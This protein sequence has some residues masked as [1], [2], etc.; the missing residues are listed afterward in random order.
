MSLRARLQR[1]GRRLDG[2]PD[3]AAAP[4]PV[5]LGPAPTATRGGRLRPGQL[6]SALASSAGGLPPM[7]PDQALSPSDAGVAPGTATGTFRGRLVIV[8]GTGAGSGM[9]VYNGT[10]GPGN[11]PVFAVVAP[12]VTTDPYGNTVGAVMTIGTFGGPGLNVDQFGNLALAGADGSLLELSPEA[13]LPFSLTAA[14]AGV[15]QTL[16][17]MQTLDLNE[18]QAGVISGLVLGSGASAKMGTL[19]TAPYAAQGMGLLLQAQND[20]A[21]D[22]PWCTWGT[23]TTQGGALTF[24]PLMA[25]GPQVLLLYSAG[26]TITVATR[27][28]GSGNITITGGATTAKA[29]CWAGGTAGPGGS[30]GQGGGG[31]GAAEYAAEPALAVGATVAYVVGGPGANSTV[32]GSAVTVTAHPGTAGSSGGA[33][34]AGGTGSANTTH[35]N[36]GQGGLGSNNGG[37]G[38]GGGSAGPGGAGHAGASATTSSG[39]AGGT[40]VSGGAAGGRGGDTAKNGTGGSAPG[41][42]GGGGGGGGGSLG[43]GSGGGGD[44]GQI[45]V[46]WSSG[47]PAIMTS[48]AAAAG[49]DQFGTAYL[50]GTELAGPDTNLYNA[51]PALKTKEVSQS[52]PNATTT[53]TWDQGGNTL[54]VAANV[55]Y[56]LRA[57]IRAAQGTVGGIA[58]S[59]QFT[60]GATIGFSSLV[61]FSGISTNSGGTVLTAWTVGALNANITN[62]PAAANAAYVIL[63]ECIFRCTTAGTISLAAICGTAGDTFNVQGGS[64]MEL[65]PVVAV[66]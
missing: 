21:T 44:N 41:G 20:G 40:A 59:I 65:T 4:V 8:F 1:L 39:A 49:T 63:V 64:Y 16:M 52:I 47:S 55:R 58:N 24:Q 5:V 38:G 51:G 60:T 36:G 46:T 6:R 19:I 12:G 15:M 25:L 10:P 28:S 22:T 18:T 32:T 56:R 17:T 30:G 14:L 13:N 27:T 11:P 34:G 9:F 45:R 54:A 3:G 23:V 66:N 33:R 29:E 50:A 31:S 7:R 2:I 43:P 57:I 62:T 53:V 26:G 48:F 35:F 42:S 61:W 37:G